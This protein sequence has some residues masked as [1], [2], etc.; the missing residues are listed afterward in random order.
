MILDTLKGLHPLKTGVEVTPSYIHHPNT[1]FKHCI[2]CQNEILTNN[3]HF[4]V[5][6]NVHSRS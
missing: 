3:L 5:R 4:D 1:L 6:D 2:V